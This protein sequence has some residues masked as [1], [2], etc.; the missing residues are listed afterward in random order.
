MKHS[1]NVWW[2]SLQ[3]WGVSLLDGNKDVVETKYFE[4]LVD[5]QDLI[6]DWCK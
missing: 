2:S 4:Y 3:K 6:Y 5:A 1:V